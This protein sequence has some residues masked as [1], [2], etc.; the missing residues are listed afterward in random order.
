[1]ETIAAPNANLTDPIGYALRKT[2]Y[3]LADPYSVTD[4]DVSALAQADYDQ[5]LDIA[6]HRLLETIYGKLLQFVDTSTGPYNQSL[7]QQAAGLL[8]RIERLAEKIES[9]Y[10]I[11]GGTL[12]GGTILLDFAEHNEEMSET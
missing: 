7:S 2:T 12:E 8:K 10:G 5:V 6:E 3:A 9:E 11:G 1:M 4:T